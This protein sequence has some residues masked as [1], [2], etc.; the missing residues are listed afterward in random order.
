MGISLCTRW[1]VLLCIA[2]VVMIGGTACVTQPDNP[3]QAIPASTQRVAFASQCALNVVTCTT[4]WPTADA[5]I[6]AADGQTVTEVT[7]NSFVVE[8][9]GGSGGVPVKFQGIGSDPGN[10]ATD[11]SFSWSYGATDNDPCT[12]TPGTEVSTES[13]PELLLATGFHYIRLTVVNDVIR[14]E[15]VLDGCTETLQDV[16]SFDFVEL[17]VEV[18]RY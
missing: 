12:L 17:Q 16:G 1:I 5:T 3:A 15:V 9:T 8:V 13:N 6:V 10:T 14:D 7:T 18:K 4:S 11:L 2:S